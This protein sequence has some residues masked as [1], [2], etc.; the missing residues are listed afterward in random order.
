M[1]RIKIKVE[2]R[3][4]IGKEGVKKLRNQGYVPAVVYGDKINIVLMVDF[5]GLKTLQ[6]IHFSESV[7]I[8]MEIIGDNKSKSIPVLIKDVQFHP[9]T[10]DVIHIDFLKVSLKEKIKVHIPIVLR[11]EAK[12]VK[13]ENGNIDQILR[14]LEVEGLPLDIPEKI[15]VDISELTI[16]HSLHVSSL[17]VPSSITVVTDQEE[18]IVTALAK[19]E[20]AEEEVVAEEEE[21]TEPEVIKEKKETSAED[22]G[23]EEEK[24]KKE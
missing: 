24:D 7:V 9:L 15:E 14:E 4:A 5:V 3:E 16:G 21:T 11:G 12:Q 23:K 17:V 10:E 13:E 22:S 19:E 1:D 2:K 18:T 8:D 6:S 20:E